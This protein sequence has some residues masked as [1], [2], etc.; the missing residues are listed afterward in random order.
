M[1]FSVNFVERTPF[2][3][4]HPRCLYKSNSLV[5][6]YKKSIL[7]Y[8]VNSVSNVPY[9]VLFLTPS[10][11]YLLKRLLINLMT[12][13]I[14][15]T[16]HLYS[17][18]KNVEMPFRFVS[19]WNTRG[20]FVGNTNASYSDQVCYRSS[21]QK[22]SIKKLLLKILQYSQENICVGVSFLIKLQATRPPTFLNRDSNTGAFMWILQNF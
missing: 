22:C 10:Q 8:F 9:V 14:L 5:F 13:S 19:M 12:Q 11:S 1:C 3:T 20:G 18:W 6:F 2:L 21:H 15:E 4:E 17:N 7:K 16:H